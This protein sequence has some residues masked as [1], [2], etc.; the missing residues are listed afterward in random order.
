MLFLNL[1]ND[2]TGVI[3]RKA[4]F[5]KTW[6]AAD[7]VWYIQY[8]QCKHVIQPFIAY[9]ANSDIDVYE[10]SHSI[11]NG[12]YVNSFTDAAALVYWD[13]TSNRGQASHFI[14]EYDLS[15]SLGS[16]ANFAFLSG[17]N[18]YM[19]ITTVGNF[20]T[21]SGFCEVA[22][23][24]SNSYGGK[25]SCSWISSTQMLITGFDKIDYDAYLG[26]YRLKVMFTSS[27]Y[28]TGVLYS[29]SGAIEMWTGPDAY[30]NLRET[31]FTLSATN[32]LDRRM[33]S[34]Y[35]GIFSSIN[36]GDLGTFTVSTITTT[37][38]SLYMSMSYNPAGTLSFS[39]DYVYMYWTFQVHNFKIPAWSSIYAV[40]TYDS[41]YQLDVSS[42]MQ[43]VSVN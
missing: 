17:S 14:M 22:G 21:A 29:V 27:S 8:I 18:Y 26:T 12:A 7:S 33:S 6:A 40:L 5:I 32:A 20:W 2:V 38:T 34:V 9:Y 11:P 16:T 36:S 37:S 31:I 42:C 43:Y 35:Q 10:I 4:Y 24:L 1:R 13:F 15:T 25:P 30:N 41:G 19:R 28:S 39:N 3:T 23:G